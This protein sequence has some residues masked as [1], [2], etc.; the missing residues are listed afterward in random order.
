MVNVTGDPAG[1]AAWEQWRDQRDA[2][3]AMNR[4]LA[5]RQG[6]LHDLNIEQL[7][8]FGVDC[9]DRLREASGLLRGGPG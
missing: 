6:G 2:W 1:V 8:A 5:G 9:M 7:R 3:L 4:E